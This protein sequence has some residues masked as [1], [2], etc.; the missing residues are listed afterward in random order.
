MMVTEQSQLLQS[1]NTIV[2]PREPED[3]YIFERCVLVMPYGNKKVV[4]VLEHF[5][6]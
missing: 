6:E 5:I 3:P 4:Q 1:L 2:P